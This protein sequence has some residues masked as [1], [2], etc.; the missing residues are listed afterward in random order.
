MTQASKERDRGGRVVKKAHI[1]VTSFMS[2]T[3]KAVDLLRNAIFVI[4][5]P[6]ALCPHPPISLYVTALL[7]H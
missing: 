5:K 6:Q 3:L 1:L 7:P 4:F 2:D